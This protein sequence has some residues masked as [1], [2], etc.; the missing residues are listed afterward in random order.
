MSQ[1]I[2][3]LQP[4]VA[5]TPISISIPT[6]IIELLI[7]LGM[8]WAMETLVF[9]PIRRAW[10][11][12]NEHIQAGLAATSATR[13]EAEEAR[14]EVRR[15]LTEA[16]R[17]AQAAI[18]EVTGEGEGLRTRRI[19]EATTEFH[20]LVNEARVQIQA[21]QVQAGAQMRNLVID[22]ALEAAGKVSGGQYT[23]PEVRELAAAVVRRD[24]GAW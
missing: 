11:E 24:G 17:Q 16:R 22:L 21:E 4:V 13:D 1:L 23:S 8:V 19:E 20:R 7:F 15:I 14:A 3:P 2:Q 9:G 12:R 5:A 10:R 18:D 6:L